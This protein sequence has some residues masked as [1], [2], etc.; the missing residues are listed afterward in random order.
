MSVKL[1]CDRCGQ[2]CKKHWELRVHTDASCLR[3]DFTR[4]LCKSCAADIMSLVNPGTDASVATTGQKAMDREHLIAAL[5][6]MQV[7]TGS[8]VCLGCGH[9]HNC[10]V[11]GCAILREAVEQLE[12][13]HFDASEPLTAEQLR[14]MHFARVQIVYP[15]QYEGDPGCCEDGVVM[16]GKLYSLE[17]LDGAGFEE[18]LSDAMDGETLDSPTG[19]YQVFRQPAE[20]G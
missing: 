13:Q 7:E 18:L 4:V 11:H 5:K 12:E 14:K 17:T 6:M 9:E 10:G 8:L 20:E 16:Y 1:F 3:A 19:N 15:P 2:E